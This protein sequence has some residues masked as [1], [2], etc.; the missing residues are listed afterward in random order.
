MMILYHVHGTIE[1]SNLLLCTFFQIFTA[2]FR[3]RKRLFGWLAKLKT[4]KQ[5]IA[6][7]KNSDFF[8]TIHY[9]SFYFKKI[10]ALCKINS[11]KSLSSSISL[12]NTVVIALALC[13]RMTTFRKEKHNTT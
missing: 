4:N 12:F 3:R 13:V 10:P 6:I 1:N 11:A 2:V 8:V 9:L 5:K 7:E